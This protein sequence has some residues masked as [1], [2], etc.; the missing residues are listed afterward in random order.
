[1]NFFSVL[2]TLI[3]SLLLSSEVVN[4]MWAS[5]SDEQLIEASDVIL[6]AELVEQKQ[7]LINKVEITVGILK[8][9]QVLK[10]NRDQAEFLLAATWIAAVISSKP[11]YTCHK[12]YTTTPT[13]ILH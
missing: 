10:G 9:G 7:V 4:A 1:M 12:P 5:L 11:E 13:T 3:F 8:V 6:I 2:L